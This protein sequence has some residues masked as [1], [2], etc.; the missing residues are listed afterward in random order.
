MELYKESLLNKIEDDLTGRNQNWDAIETHM[1]ESAQKHIT[2]SG[3]NENGRY[4]RFDDGTQIC[5]YVGEQT[6]SIDNILISGLYYGLIFLD[7]PASFI[8][9]PAA[10]IGHERHPNSGASWGLVRGTSP[11]R[12]TIN[13]LYLESCPSASMTVSYIAIGRW[14]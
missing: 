6:V 8:S 2:E 7:F 13:H 9:I 1:A 3:E 10:S 12:V 5:W 4:V 11:T 14:K